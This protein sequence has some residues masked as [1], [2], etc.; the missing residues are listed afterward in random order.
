M[1]QP[2]LVFRTGLLLQLRNW[3]ALCGILDA[4]HQGYN[5]L[6]DYANH[7]RYADG[8]GACLQVLL[9]RRTPQSLRQGKQLPEDE[10]SIDLLNPNLLYRFAKSL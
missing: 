9:A 8:T 5:L 4:G 1:G 10:S 2:H 3:R 7:S 6:D